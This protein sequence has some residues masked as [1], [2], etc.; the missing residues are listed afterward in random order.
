MSAQI[1]TSQPGDWAYKPWIMVRATEDYA[2]YGFYGPTLGFQNIQCADTS[3]E[4]APFTMH[5]A[6]HLAVWAY[7]LNNW[8]WCNNGPEIQ[9]SGFTLTSARAGG[10]GRTRAK[11]SPTAPGSSCAATTVPTSRSVRKNG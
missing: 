9:N 7:W 10:G 3:Y 2:H 4:A 1:T 8:V 5:I 11:T 6:E